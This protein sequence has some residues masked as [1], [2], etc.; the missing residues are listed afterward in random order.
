[1]ILGRVELDCCG[2]HAFPR[3]GLTSQSNDTGGPGA[4]DSPRRGAP[5]G[6]LPVP[7]PPQRMPGLR[8]GRMLKRWRYV[9]VFGPE[10][11][12]CAGWARVGPTRQAWWAVWDRREQ[13][14]HER[15]RLLFGRGRVA[16]EPGRVAVE[17]GM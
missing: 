16:L 10:L 8:A 15:T 2:A 14:L 9:G 6:P 7:V 3:I 1:R 4:L 13:E 11:M 5:L 12:L 17:D